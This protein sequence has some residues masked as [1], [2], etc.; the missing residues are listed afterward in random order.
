MD[1]PLLS[2][3][4]LAPVVRAALGDST[5]WP[6]DWSS[7]AIDVDLINPAT[8]GLFRVAGTAKTAFGGTLTWRVVLKV[9]HEVD[10]V[11]TPLEFGYLKEPSDWNYRKREVLARR[12]SVLDTFTG[13]LRPVTCFG[14]E[15]VGDATAWL[16]LEELDA[17]SQ[18]SV[19]PNPALTQAA[20]DLGA[21]A[22]QGLGLVTELSRHPWA[23]HG[24]LRG[25]VATGRKMGTDHALGHDGCWEH[26]LL[27]Q[28]L[29]AS[30]R[31]IVSAFMGA[32]D[33][34]LDRLDQLPR[35]VA[36]H[37]AQ[38]RNLVPD[39]EPG[40]GTVAI[41][42]SFVGTAP[43]GLD[44]GLHVSANVVDGGVDTG[45]AEEHLEIAT[46]VY[47]EGLRAHGWRG[48]EDEVRVAAVT[49]GAL[50]MVPW[51]VDHVAWL[52]PEFGDVDPWPQAEAE[53]RGVSVDRVMDSWSQA[54]RFILH[55]AERASGSLRG[56]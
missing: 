51:L 9:V 26:P 15:D 18:S 35:T 13:P 45:N 32:A 17:A 41:D 40:S 30:T 6:L 27:R 44:L 5:A 54:F 20:Y 19:W 49:A 33:V 11:G 38:W 34:M 47:L 3:E 56:E 2:A 55:M 46:S 28:R 31:S 23:A 16:W 50:K 14:T 36:H 21:F 10:L 37:D 24:W 29:P 4:C 25:W 52:C 12:S 39:Q 43:I 7:E 1:A 8:A 42:W 53:V 48:D 22:A